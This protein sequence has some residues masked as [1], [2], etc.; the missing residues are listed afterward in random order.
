MY[1]ADYWKY[2]LKV[3]HVFVRVTHVFV[4]VIYLNI[5]GHSGT[6]PNLFKEHFDGLSE[7]YITVMSDLNQLQHYLTLCM[8]KT[9]LR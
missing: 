8:S 9:E 5:L 1:K 4:R 3:T 6:Y 2:I 7:V